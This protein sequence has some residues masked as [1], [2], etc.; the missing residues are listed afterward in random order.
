MERDVFEVRRTS[1]VSLQYLSISCTKC[2][3][4]HVPDEQKSTLA[5]YAFSTPYLYDGLR[6]GGVPKYV[7]CA[8][9]LTTTGECNDTMVCVNRGTTDL[10]ILSSL[11]PGS[12][13][14]V[15]N[16]DTYGEALNESLCNVVSGEQVK[17]A[18]TTIREQGFTGDYVVSEHVFSKVS[19]LTPYPISSLRLLFTLF[20]FCIKGTTCDGDSRK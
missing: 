18:E 19:C 10:D 20:L 9:K 4:I 8:D 11:L 15:L 2:F 13:I 3:C 16:N 17:I 12:N 7:D 1:Q 14:V 5:D 6:F